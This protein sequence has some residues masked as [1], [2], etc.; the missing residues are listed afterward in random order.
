[1]E[2]LNIKINELEAKLQTLQAKNK[3]LKRDNRKALK[4][5]QQHLKKNTCLK[6]W[7]TNAHFF[8]KAYSTRK[9]VKKCMSQVFNKL[10]EHNADLGK[11]V[12][13]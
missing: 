3:L 10:D 11:Y 1:M 12:G 8:Q 7:N 9:R 5:H 2:L 4:L 13:I 6:K